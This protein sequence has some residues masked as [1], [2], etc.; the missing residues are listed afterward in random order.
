[1]VRYFNLN[2]NAEQKADNFQ[3]L[4]A[5]KK[6]RLPHISLIKSKPFDD[7]PPPLG[8]YNPNY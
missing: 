2:L 4:E 3:K 7:V 1:M 6:M 5:A 8:F